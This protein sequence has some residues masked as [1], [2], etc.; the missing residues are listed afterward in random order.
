MAENFRGR[1]GIIIGGGAS[2]LMAAITAAEQG[3][4]VTVI[5]HTARPGKKILST[6]NGKCNLTNLYMDPSFYRSDEKG[7]WGTAIRNF[8]PK[9]AVAFFRNLGVL[10]MDRGGYVYPMSGQAQTV[11]DALLRGAKRAGVKI[12][13]GCEVEKAGRKK[14]HFEVTTN[15]GTFTGDFLIL[16]CGSK[17]AKATGSDGSGYEL[18]KQFGHRIIKPLP[19]LV[20]LRCEGDLLPKAS[21]VPGGCPCEHPDGGWERRRKG[22]RGT[23]DYRLRNLR[24]SGISGEPVRRKTAGPEKESS[25]IF[26]LSAGS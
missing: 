9:A 7:F 19:A 17:A 23:A 6:G 18:A 16:A 12:V 5:E 21:G 4:A 10:T 3:A 8:P 25:G 24:H 1:K 14:E 20:Q 22:P 26:K 11:L 13:T 15:L 2:G